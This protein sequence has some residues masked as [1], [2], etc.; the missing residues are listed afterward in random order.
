MRAADHPA[1]GDA[2]SNR[3]AELAALSDEPG[4]LTRLYLSPAHRR[5]IDLVS[6]WMR[7]AGMSV[8][9]DPLASVVGRYE[10]QDGGTKTLL[11]GSHIDSVR[12]AGRFDGPLGVV[13]AIEVVKAAFKSGK[14]YPFAIEVVA[15]GDEE[16]VRFATTLGGSRALA[17]KFDEQALDELDES[18]I[19]RREALAAF[20]CDPSRVAAEKR[21][22]D[23]TVGYVEIHIEQ[24]PVLEKEGLPLGVVTTIDG[25]TRAT[26]DVGGVAGHA[27]TVPMAMR[28]D[29]LTA[30]AEM[31]LAIEERARRR[32]NLVAT[33]GKRGTALGAQHH[34][35]PRPLHA[36]YPQPRRRGARQSGGGHQDD[37]RCHRGAPRGDATIDTRSPG[38]GGA[39]RRKTLG[40]VGGG[41][42]KLRGCAAADTQRRRP[43]RHGLRQGHPLR[44]AV[45]PLPRR[46]EPQS[47]RIRFGRGHRH[48]GA[49]SLE[50]FR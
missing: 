43:R 9:L 21:P 37:A 24:G 26:I 19:S 1:F 28:H 33:V 31:L 25:V 45:C 41:R 8:R 14:R 29:A 49:R 13:T 11:L 48:C 2:I 32:P 6:Y 42:R 22:P 46:R 3:L 12:N 17:G 15:F 7:D 47:G 16:G 18:T 27:G 4:R 20:G 5:A 30:A 50:F 39:L 23:R 10:G 44:H 34:S 40:P 35:G 36:R 38:A